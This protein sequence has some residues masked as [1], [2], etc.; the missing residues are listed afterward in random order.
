ML[1]TSVACSDVILHARLFFIFFLTSCKTLGRCS[2]NPGYWHRQYASS[3]HCVL[4][5]DRKQIDLLED[6]LVYCTIHINNDNKKKNKRHIQIMTE[7][8]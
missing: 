8:C 7:D 1:S 3:E 4:A 6:S 5:S 2:R